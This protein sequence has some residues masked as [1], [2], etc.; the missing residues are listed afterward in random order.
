MKISNQNMKFYITENYILTSFCIPKDTTVLVFTWQF[1]KPIHPGIIP[2]SVTH[3]EFGKYFD[4]PI[5]VN[6]IPKSVTHITFGDCFN[7][8][9]Q[10]GALPELLTHINLGANFNQTIYPG[11]LPE[12]VTHVTLGIMFYQSILPKSIPASVTHIVILSLNKPIQSGVFPESLTH[13]YLPILPKVV[14]CLDYLPQESIN[15]L[16]YCPCLDIDY[17]SPHNQN[18]RKL[19]HHLHTYWIKRAVCITLPSSCKCSDIKRIVC[20]FLDLCV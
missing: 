13:L 16:L 8:L 19:C 1:N 20:G 9:I 11:L 5:L 12:S 17:V 14:N 10:P 6:T 3:I 2:E 4:K 18:M 15:L 7:S